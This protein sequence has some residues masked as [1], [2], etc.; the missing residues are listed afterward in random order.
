MNTKASAQNPPLLTALEISSETQG[1]ERHVNSWVSPPDDKQLTRLSFVDQLDEGGQKNCKSLMR[2]GR[3]I[4]LCAACISFFLAMTLEDKIA[5]GGMCLL[6]MAIVWISELIQL[7]V[8]GLIPVF[9]YA[10]AG[11]LGEKD[12]AANFWKPSSFLFAVGF[13]MGI[14]IERWDVHKRIT[15]TMVLCAG[16]NVSLL[17]FMM[18]FAV[19]LLSMWISNT[20]T[21]L[22]MLPVVRSFLAKV[23]DKHK[24]FK[25]AM[26]LAVGWSATIGGLSTPV[27]T[28]TNILFLGIYEDN[29]NAKFEFGTF[30]AFAIPISFLLLITAWL[31][32]CWWHVWGKE[33][34][35]VDVQIFRDVKRELGRMKYEEYVVTI[36]VVI[37]V[38]FWCFSSLLKKHIIPMKKMGSAS[39]GLFW[40]MPLFFIPTK[41]KKLEKSADGKK[42]VPAKHILDWSYAMPRFKWQILFIF[43]GGFI[44]AHGTKESGFAKWVAS[45]MSPMPELALVAVVVFVICFLTEVISNMACVQIFGPILISVAVEMCISPLKM[46]LVVCFASSYAFMMPMAGGPNMLVYGTGEDFDLKFM[47]KH[48]FVLN[49]FACIVGTLYLQYIL[50][51]ILNP[52]QYGPPKM[53]GNGTLPVCGDPQPW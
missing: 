53:E 16:E 46:L 50:P 26:L 4:S 28:P 32:V 35:K 1:I 13:L 41:N 17:L 15:A 52:A 3:W 30:M 39:V 37:L 24:D 42:M 22:C 6:T 11:I 23:D 12:S 20:A 44:V 45:L 38:V 51:A 47:I 31:L 19:Y 48:G 18:M 8:S 33:K 43:G 40:T 49:I 10:A 14:S 25:G 2:F 5:R 9:L 36:Y 27:G 34:I 7:E 29:W 21:I